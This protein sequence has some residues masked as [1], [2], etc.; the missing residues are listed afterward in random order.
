MLHLDAS[1]PESAKEEA[2]LGTCLQRWGRFPNKVAG[3]KV[4][5]GT[6]G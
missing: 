5:L 3:N 2:K 6:M 1:V 4:S